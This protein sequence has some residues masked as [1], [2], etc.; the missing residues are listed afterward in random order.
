MSFLVQ[1]LTGNLKP[2][3]NKNETELYADGANLFRDT[4]AVGGKL[5]LTNERLIFLPHNM[6]FNKKEEYINLTQINSTK[7]VKTMDVIDNGL[8]ITLNDDNELK[9]V[10]DNREEWI[11]K[12]AKTKSE[13]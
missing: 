5:I 10:V 11:S 13:I 6:N 9:F 8:R 12:I 3:M 1:L 7:R 4:V 2:E